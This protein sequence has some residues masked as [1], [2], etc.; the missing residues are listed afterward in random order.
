VLAPDYGQSSGTDANAL[1]NFKINGVGFAAFMK[2]TA[3]LVLTT[4]TRRLPTGPP[5]S[6]F[7][8]SLRKFLANTAVVRFAIHMVKSRSSRSDR[9]LQRPKR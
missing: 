2:L 7:H 9:L 4:Y 3:E 6:F 5:R 8:G 1:L